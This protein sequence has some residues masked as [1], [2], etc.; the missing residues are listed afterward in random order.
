[1]WYTVDVR[2]LN[3]IRKEWLT[4]LRLLKTPDQADRMTELEKAQYLINDRNISLA[5]LAR[6][7]DIPEQ[8]LRNLRQNQDRMNYTSWQR[9][10]ILANMF[11]QHYIDNP[12]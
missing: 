9:I 8:S 11:D 10:H 4:L 3:M 12:D 7:T 2:V 1:M 5:K 6:K